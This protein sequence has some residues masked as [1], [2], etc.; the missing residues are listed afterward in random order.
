MCNTFRQE[1]S[2]FIYHSTL[3]NNFCLS[4]SRFGEQNV[5]ISARVILC[6]CMNKNI[7]SF[8]S[9]RAK[10]KRNVQ[11]IQ[12]GRLSFHLSFN[13]TQQ[14]L[15]KSEK[16]LITKRLD[17]CWGAFVCVYDQNYALVILTQPK[18]KMC[19][20]FRLE[21]SVLIYHTTLQNHFCLGLSSFGEL[22]FGSVLG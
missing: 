6:V 20:I 17:K 2:F 21:E 19:K 8:N 12:I 1:D 9:N 7:C 15:S 4:L 10:N 18:T 22:N 5:S 3:H 11:Y 13:I 14:L 16:V